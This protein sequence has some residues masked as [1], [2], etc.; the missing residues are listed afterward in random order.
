MGVGGSSSQCPGRGAGSLT[1]E[2]R[3]GQPQHRSWASGGALVP[4]RGQ[5]C[6]CLSF[7]KAG[8]SFK[9]KSLYFARGRRGESTLQQ[10]LQIPSDRLLAA[11]NSQE[12]RAPFGLIGPQGANPRP[13]LAAEKGS[14]PW[15]L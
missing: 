8:P 4:V 3:L 11:L 14:W 12:V 9:W 10:K 7:G 15:L 5:G 1:K 2:E 13:T 6:R